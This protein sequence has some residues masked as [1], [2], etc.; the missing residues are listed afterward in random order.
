MLTVAV[1]QPNKIIINATSIQVQCPGETVDV[2]TLSIQGGVTP[3][4][5]SWTG[6]NNFTATTPSIFSVTAGSYTLV[7]TDANN[8]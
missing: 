3:Y 4:A 1:S 7:V 8:C 2:V 6:P 5:Y